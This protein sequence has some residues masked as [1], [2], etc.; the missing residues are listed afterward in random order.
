MCVSLEGTT[1]VSHSMLLGRS[2]S[3]PLRITSRPRS[4]H[5]KRCA[6]CRVV[7]IMQAEAAAQNAVGC[8]YPLHAVRNDWPGTPGIGVIA[9]RLVLVLRHSNRPSLERV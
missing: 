4:C 5:R 9:S 2:T 8:A 3:P 7:S 6:L 1:T